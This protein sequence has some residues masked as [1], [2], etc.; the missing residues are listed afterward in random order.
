[1]KSDLYTHL[2]DLLDSSKS[3]LEVHNGY[4]SHDKA[5]SADQTSVLSNNTLLNIRASTDRMLDEYEI[6]HGLSD[7]EIRV[8]LKIVAKEYEDCGRKRGAILRY[9]KHFQE[10]EAKAKVGDK[11]LYTKLRAMDTKINHMR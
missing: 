10:V 8:L 3:M 9:I 2:L 5:R 6:N 7:S 1:M 4:H 11:K